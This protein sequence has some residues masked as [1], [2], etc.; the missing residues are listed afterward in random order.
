MFPIALFFICHHHFHFRSF[1]FHYLCPTSCERLTELSKFSCQGRLRTQ[2]IFKHLLLTLSELWLFVVDGVLPVEITAFSSA[3]GQ[4]PKLLEV[5]EYSVRLGLQF[6]SQLSVDALVCEVKFCC[7]IRGRL[8]D[9]KPCKHFMTLQPLSCCEMSTV[10]QQGQLDRHQVKQICDFIP[11]CHIQWKFKPCCHRAQWRV[12]T[13]AFKGLARLADTWWP[14]QMVAG[15][16][17]CA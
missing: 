15:R 2:N 12:L 4:N 17:S 16:L 1:S 8:K 13:P 5:K 3:L 14:L 6:S 9:H 10:T 11:L 7:S